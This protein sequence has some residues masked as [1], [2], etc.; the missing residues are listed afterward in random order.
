MSGTRA[1]QVD[2]DRWR[3]ASLAFEHVGDLDDGDVLCDGE[4]RPVIKRSRQYG[5]GLDVA[6]GPD[7]VSSLRHVDNGKGRQREHHQLDRLCETG[8]CFAQRVP[9]ARPSART[10]VLLCGGVNRGERPKGMPL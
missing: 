9:A 8:C 7:G 6:N 4:R 3:R 10:L 5:P 1:E 2:A